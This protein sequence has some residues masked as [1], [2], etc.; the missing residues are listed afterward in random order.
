MGMQ[1][2]GARHFDAPGLTTVARATTGTSSRATVTIAELLGVLLAE[3]DAGLG[4][5]HFEQYM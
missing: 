1:P 3:T 2:P 5:K 4:L